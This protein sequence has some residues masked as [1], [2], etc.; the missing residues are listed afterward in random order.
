MCS[1]FEGSFA[2]NGKIKNASIAPSESAK[3]ASELTKSYSLCENHS[4]VNLLGT[5]APNPLPTE[6]I[7]DPIKEIL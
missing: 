3:E 5:A 7:A 6:A 4:A 1:R 2:M